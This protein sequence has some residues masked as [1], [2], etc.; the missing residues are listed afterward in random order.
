MN[1]ITS[2]SDGILII[3]LGNTCELNINLERFIIGVYFVS[4]MIVFFMEDGNKNTNN[5]YG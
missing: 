5:Q 4:A 3:L 1:V 2:I